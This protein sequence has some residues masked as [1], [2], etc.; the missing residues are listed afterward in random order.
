MA[1]EKYFYHAKSLA[2]VGGIIAHL[3]FISKCFALKAGDEK[4]L[5][6]AFLYP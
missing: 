6:D 3:H 5:S 2:F 1:D 4:Q